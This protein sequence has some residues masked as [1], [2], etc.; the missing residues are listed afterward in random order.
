M[1]IIIIII[2]LLLY[3]DVFIV[4]SLKVASPNSR[5]LSWYYT[6]EEL[7]TNKIVLTERKSPV[8]SSRKIKGV[9]HTKIIKDS[10]IFCWK[11]M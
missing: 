4:V 5:I 2:M 10:L 9:P 1:I 7:L 8:D 3:T 6:Q 11:I